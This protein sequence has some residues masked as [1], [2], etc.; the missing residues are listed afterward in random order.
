MTMH[1]YR[2]AMSKLAEVVRC[3]TKLPAACALSFGFLG[4]LA[5]PHIGGLFP[6]EA[7]VTLTL[8]FCSAVVG[9]VAA[10]LASLLCKGHWALH[11]T[12]IIAGAAGRILG[13]RLFEGAH[14][15]EYGLRILSRPPFLSLVVATVAV[16]SAFWL[17][18]L[19]L[20]RQRPNNSSKPTPLRGAA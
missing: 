1:I 20:A 14:S 10:A 3:A 8:T 12:F 17:Y 16:S 9:A 6:L 13:P 2:A 5:L 19:R 7:P 4:W 11:V 15:F 18:K